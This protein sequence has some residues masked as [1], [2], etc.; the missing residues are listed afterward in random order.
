M[1]FRLFSFFFLFVFVFFY[2]SAFIVFETENALIT[3]LGKIKTFV[4]KVS[5]G[6]LIKIY[7]P[8]LHFKVPFFQEQIKFDMR[9]NLLDVQSTRITTAEKKDVIVDFY[10][11]WRINNLALYYTRTGGFLDKGEHLLGQKVLAALKAEF[12]KRTIKE[13]VHGERME[14]MIRL[15]ETT[16]E[17]TKS[18]GASIVD[19]RVK[20]IDLPYEVRNSVYLRMRAERERVASETRANANADAVMI[21]ATA[22]KERRVTLAEARYIVN[23][24]KGSGDAEAAAIYALSYNKNVN[25]YCFYRSLSAY[26]EIFSNN[27]M[28]ILSPKGDFFKFFSNNLNFKN[29]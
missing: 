16:D 22:E 20:K 11:V 14:L 5:T 29:D 21:K 23:K 8:G 27:D 1:L 13:V 9:A 19:V 7:Y 6:E 18:M 10:I 24:I 12:G 17:S 4:P 2:F 3:Q 15:K 28:F 26:K 25:F